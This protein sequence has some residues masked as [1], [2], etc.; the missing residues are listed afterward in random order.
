MPPNEYLTQS[1]WKRRAVSLTPPTLECGSSNAKN[2]PRRHRGHRERHVGEAA[3]PSRNLC[4]GGTPVLRSLRRSGMA[5]HAKAIVWHWYYSAKQPLLLWKIAVRVAWAS[6]K[7][8]AAPHAA[9][10]TPSNAKNSPRRHRGHRERHV[11]EAAYPPR[12]LCHG[13]TPVLL[14][15]QAKRLAPPYKSNRVALVAS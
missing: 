5:R 14:S 11:G 15:P 7:C 12:N 4:H 8:R 3:C 10:R 2:S 9:A 6:A 1:Q 13:G